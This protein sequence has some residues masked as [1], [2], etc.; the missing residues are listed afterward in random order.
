MYAYIHNVVRECFVCYIVQ[1]ESITIT[2]AR[3]NEE[4]GLERFLCIKLVPKVVDF[5]SADHAIRQSRCT[6]NAAPQRAY[7]YNYIYRLH[8]HNEQ[9]TYFR[10]KI[11]LPGDD[12]SFL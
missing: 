10:R 5:C 9:Q 1:P 3:N 12:E 6:Q 2:E 7:T 8:R 11:N 4:K